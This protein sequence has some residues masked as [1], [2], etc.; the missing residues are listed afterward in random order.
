MLGTAHEGGYDGCDPEKSTEGTTKYSVE[1]AQGNLLG[2]TTAESNDNEHSD[3]GVSEKPAEQ[4]TRY[5]VQDS[6]GEV[7]GTAIAERDS[8]NHDVARQGTELP[9]FEK[10]VKEENTVKRVPPIPRERSSS[11]TRCESLQTLSLIHI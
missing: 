5:S 4:T 11:F 7:L 8:G 10:D 3:S 6:N 1:D 9:S 2:S